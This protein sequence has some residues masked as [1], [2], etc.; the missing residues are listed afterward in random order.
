MT[1]PTESVS[2]NSDE[3]QAREAIRHVHDEW[4]EANRDC[5]IPRMR[6]C[7]VGERYLMYNLNGHPY[8]GLDE[9]TALWEAL[10]SK[11]V[12]IPDMEQPLN[13]RLDVHGDFAWLACDSIIRITAPE[14]QPGLPT[15][16]FRVR[17]TEIYE[18]S[19]GD[20][21]IVH[22]HCSP[23]APED[24]ERVPFGD[25]AASRPEHV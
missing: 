20:W 16:P 19:G 17:S 23:H 14:V 3:S 11:G 8:W 12:A 25:S 15:E 9:K 6:A 4:W 2:V 5:D 24:Q 22:F 21:R 18:R 10:G 7:F 13:L 1:T